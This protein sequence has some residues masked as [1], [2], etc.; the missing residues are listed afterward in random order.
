MS[1]AHTAL[2]YVH[3]LL[4]VFWIGAD[5]GVFIAGF[6][7]IN[8]NLSVVQRTMAI[9]LGLVIDRLPRI[10]FV[11]ILPVGLQLA[12]IG[13]H[14]DLPN[15]VLGIIWFLSAIWL[16]VVLVGMVRPNTQLAKRAHLIERMFQW[17]GLIGAGGG[18]LVLASTGGVPQFLAIK[19]ILFGAICGLVVLL[20]RS[21]NP[22]LAAFAAISTSGSTPALEATMRRGM[23]VTYVWVLA[24]YAAVLI[25]AWVGIAKA[26]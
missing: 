26:A 11:L 17:F 10:C 21:F 12:K 7:F 2:I 1:L 14:L 25:A 6:F 9:E 4:L 24:I 3:I 23:Y 19:F 22:T 8:P 18:G 20:E 13:N 16:V 15:D 5:I